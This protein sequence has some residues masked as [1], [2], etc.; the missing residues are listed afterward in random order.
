ME[1]PLAGRNG[2]KAAPLQPIIDDLSAD[3]G[4]V[5]GG[6]SIILQFQEE[7]CLGGCRGGER[8]GGRQGIEKKSGVGEL[9]REGSR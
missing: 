3:Q 8:F 4:G 6:R 1:T 2:G 9:G 5:D 7:T